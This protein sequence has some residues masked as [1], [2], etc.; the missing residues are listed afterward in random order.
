MTRSAFAEGSTWIPM[1]VVSLMGIAASIV[2]WRVG[3]SIRSAVRQNDEALDHALET[4]LSPAHGPDRPLAQRLLAPLARL[5]AEVPRGD[6][7]RWVVHGEAAGLYATYLEACDDALRGQRFFERS[8]ITVGHSLTGIALVFTFGLIAWVLASEVPT[9]IQGVAQTGDARAGQAGTDA[10]QRA[11][12]L[13]GAKFAVSA[14]GLLLALVFRSVVDGWRARIAEGVSTSLTRHREMFVSAEDYRAERLR[15]DLARAQASIGEIVVARAE[16]V[17]QRLDQLASIEVSV[18]DMGNEVKSHLGLL[19]KQHVADQICDAMAELRVFADQV[20]ERL[21][22][23]LSESLT[24]GLAKL[25][26]AL[27]MIR[28]TIEGQA[29]T[30]VERLISQIR[31]M[32]S[33][34]FQAESQQMTDAMAGLR[35]VLP[36]LEAQLRRMTD[37][38]DRQMRERTEDQHRL[39]AELLR[40]VQGVVDANERSQAALE[41][42]LGRV[43]RVAE[44]STEALRTQLSTS[45]EEAVKGLFEAAGAGVRELKAQLVQINEMATGNVSAFGQ[46]VAVSSRALL[47]AR[48]SLDHALA[49]VRGMA[50]ELRDGLSGARDS[51]AAAERAGGTFS[52]AGIALGD[53]ARRTHEIVVNLGSRLEQEA[54]VIESHRAL[55]AQLDA[56][57]LPALEKAFAG[58]TEAIEEQSRKLQQGWLQLAERVKQTVDRCGAGLQ[59]SVEQ[60][61][62]QVGL[63]QKQLDRAQGRPGRP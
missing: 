43:G 35:A 46:E 11:V 59:E 14:L 33:G 48:E 22:S 3:E 41:D 6:G 26:V 38:V 2:V 25:G 20:A 9:A 7:G 13:M 18:K 61:A 34:G 17:T 29:K 57:V 51:L 21:K 39:Q 58:Y 56:Q 53:A 36:G 49:A 52:N 8:L 44:E 10:L 50:A 55:A 31:D 28:S 24:E 42:L 40:Q 5:L 12:G 62:D 63:L 19:M 60:L 15:T 47:S 4:A 32:M 27:D 30:D 54:G 23:G 1:L 16:A 45:G 37:D